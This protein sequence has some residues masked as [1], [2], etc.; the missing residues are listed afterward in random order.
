[1]LETYPRPSRLALHVSSPRQM[2]GSPLTCQMPRLDLPKRKPTRGPINRETGTRYSFQN[3]ICSRVGLDCCNTMRKPSDRRVRSANMAFGAPFLRN[4]SKNRGTSSGVSS[5][6]LAMT[7]TAVLRGHADLPAEACKA[8]SSGNAND[9]VR[10][11]KQQRLL[12]PEYPASKSP[13]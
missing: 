13:R 8:R 5:Q 6:S 7:I 12:Y 10:E 9:R 3:K 11:E 2:L 1:M 4:P